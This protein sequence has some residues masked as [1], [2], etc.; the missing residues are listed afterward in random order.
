[1]KKNAPLALPYFNL[2]A[3]P[4]SPFIIRPTKAEVR[5]AARI[6]HLKDAAIVAA[7][8]KG[9]ADYLVTHDVK[10]LLNHA[11]AIA[12]AYGIMVLT[13][14]ELLSALTN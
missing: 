2:L 7:A 3:D 9:K 4:F 5:K 14:A 13:P 12:K 1:L 6:V 11:T 10:H 8:A